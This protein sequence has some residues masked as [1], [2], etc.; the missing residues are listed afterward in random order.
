MGLT[1]NTAIVTVAEVEGIL[2]EKTLA[3]LDS[4]GATV[5]IALNEATNFL[6]RWARGQKGQDPA[7]IS[8]TSDLKHAAA[9][10]VGWTVFGADPDPSALEK[11]ERH[12]R[13]LEEALDAIVLESTSG[14]PTV[15]GRRLP[16]M[17]NV[18]AG[19]P[20]TRGSST[21]RTTTTYIHRG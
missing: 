2:F 8:N 3:N 12:K 5:A 20:L 21:V 16:V 15:G 1:A 17:F 6:M 4:G 10:W 9:Y 19:A 14:R 18:D 11:S 13:S 7:T